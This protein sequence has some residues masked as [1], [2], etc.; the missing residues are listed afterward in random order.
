MC[1]DAWKSK[2]RSLGLNRDESNRL[3]RTREIRDD[4]R[5]IMTTANSSPTSCVLLEF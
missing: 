4:N 1:Q 3:L 2:G 5:A